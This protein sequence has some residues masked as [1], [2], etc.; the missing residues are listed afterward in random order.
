LNETKRIYHNLFARSKVP[1]S[2]LCRQGEEVVRG[3]VKFSLGEAN[4][5]SITG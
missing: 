3:D 5:K 4:W 2:M 1:V